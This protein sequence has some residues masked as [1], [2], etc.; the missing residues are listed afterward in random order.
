MSGRGLAYWSDGTEERIVY[1]TPG[2]HLIALDAATGRPILEFGDGG[3]VDLKLEADQ[4]MDPVTSDIGL[5][6]A[7][8]IANDV[9]VVGDFVSIAVENADATGKSI[10]ALL[11]LQLGVDEIDIVWTAIMIK[12]Y[13]AKSFIATSYIK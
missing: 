3:V 4:Q 7:P 13:F 9:I 2:Y 8:I 5:Q 1:V 6:A 11:A 12:R 10:E